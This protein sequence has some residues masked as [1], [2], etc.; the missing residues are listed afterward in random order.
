MKTN[1]VLVVM[2]GLVWSGVAMA[3]EEPQ[4]RPGA[5]VRCLVRI[6]CD[7]SILPLDVETVEVLLT[8]PGVGVAAVREV[9][10]EGKLG[11]NVEISF[12][13]LGS[14][15]REE[16]LPAG[17][18]GAP[19]M[20][21]GMMM[22]G[23]GGPRG[24]RGARLREPVSVPG[25]LSGVVEVWIMGG[26]TDQAAKLLAVVCKRLEGALAGAYKVQAEQLG[27]E[28]E[29]ADAQLTDAQAGL[30]RLQEA[31]RELT[32]KAGVSDLSREK[33]LD[34]IREF[35]QQKREHKME[36]VGLRARRM[37]LE[38]AVNRISLSVKDRL[39]KD[40]IAMDLARIVG[41]REQHITKMDTPE[42]GKTETVESIKLGEMLTEARL[43]LAERRE[44][45]SRQAGGEVLGKLTG[46][47]AE[48]SIDAATAE[49]RLVHITKQ[50]AEIKGKGL[51]EL[52]DTYERE[53]A[54]RLPLAVEAVEQAIR[55]QGEL[56]RQMQAGRAPTVTVIGGE[57]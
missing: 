47:L 34:E 22:P 11:E 53:V 12:Y 29:V 1:V 45:L 14:R 23:P 50:L 18:M 49:G 31:Q 4:E 6:A 40:P 38:Q 57:D 26:Q 8:S 2:L 48:L 55:R 10:P 17:G 32:T 16:G 39:A 5:E 43:Q 46:E 13:T 54:V 41:L 51:L 44:A 21:P 20:V 33:V 35:E 37:A 19:G 42:T 56:S 52:A 30:Q 24:G 25:V 15:Q 27:R 28:K 9:M 36:L 3:E 7:P